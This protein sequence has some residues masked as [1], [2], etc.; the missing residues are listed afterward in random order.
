M[1]YNHLRQ[2]YSRD[3]VYYYRME[4][5]QE[6][7]FLIKN[8]EQALSLFQVAESVV[9]YKSKK[10]EIEAV[11]QAM[12]ELNIDCSFI[13]TSNERNTL[14]ENSQTIEILPFLESV[15]SFL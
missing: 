11:F 8:R 5:N 15:L 13:I 7:D 3:Q 12:E 9:S 14:T 10:H 4:S 1:V 6:I 2:K